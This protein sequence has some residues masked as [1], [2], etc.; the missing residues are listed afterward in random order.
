MVLP[1]DMAKIEAKGRAFTAW[2]VYFGWEIFA[3]CCRESHLESRKKRV[4]VS[5][6]L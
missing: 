4:E 2:I 3:N 1:L 5:A 6:E